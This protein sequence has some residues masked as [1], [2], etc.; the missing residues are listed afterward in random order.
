MGIGE[1]VAHVL[2]GNHGA[3]QGVSV[4]FPLIEWMGLRGELSGELGTCLWAWRT[5]GL[6]C[7][8]YLRSE[9]RKC[10]YGPKAERKRATLRARAAWVLG[11]LKFAQFGRLSLR[12]MESYLHRA[13]CWAPPWSWQCPCKWQFYHLDFN[14][15]MHTCLS[16]HG[17]HTGNK[18]EAGMNECFF[19]TRCGPHGREKQP[20]AALN[21]IHHGRQCF[22]WRRM[23]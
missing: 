9:G 15:S 12:K 7:D 6:V 20:E 4:P 17:G 18:E 11:S 10:R 22:S 19:W 13:P 3:W 16:S 8:T 23:D 21:P 14:T 5:W 1:R 2:R